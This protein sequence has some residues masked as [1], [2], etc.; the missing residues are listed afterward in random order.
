MRRL[1]IGLLVSVVGAG[2]LF[3]ASSS[4]AYNE[5]SG[6]LCETCH[7]GFVGRGSLHDVHT[8]ITNNCG[9]CHPSNPGSKPV[10]TSSASD[11]TAFSCLGCHG[12]DYGSTIGQQAAGLRV[13]HVNAGQSCSPCHDGDPSPVLPEN[14][15]PVHYGRGDVSLTDAC[16]DNLDNDGDGV[17]DNNDT[18]CTT[19]VK[20]TTWGK[21]KSLYSE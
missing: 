4:I 7:G 14:I 17:K 2:L 5:Y 18:D 8:N 21:I 3:V 11:G 10:N 6:S 15:E 9:M 1:A 20:V 13:R 16:A 12:T 19:P